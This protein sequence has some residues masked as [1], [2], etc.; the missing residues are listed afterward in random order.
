MFIR[1]DAGVMLSCCG[2]LGNWVVR[3]NQATERHPTKPG[4]LS[5]MVVNQD[6]WAEPYPTMPNHLSNMVVNQDQWAEQ[7]CRH[8]SRPD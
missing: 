2:L 6:Q 5:N 8:L 1:P 7:Q 3:E 4:H